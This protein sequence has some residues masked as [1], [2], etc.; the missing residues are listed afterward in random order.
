MIS[1][2]NFLPL[3]VA[4]GTITVSK[5]GPKETSYIDMIA[6]MSGHDDLDW[7]I[8]ESPE[9]KFRY[10]SNHFDYAMRVQ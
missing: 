8:H 5:M 2:Y 1:N 3:E 7:T 6:G 10:R 9:A 4:S